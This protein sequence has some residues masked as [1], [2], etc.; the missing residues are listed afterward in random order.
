M[1][2]FSRT[3]CKWQG[4]K[5]RITSHF[6][7]SKSYSGS[8][9]SS[10]NEVKYFY[11]SSCTVQVL[12]TMAYYVHSGHRLWTNYRGRQSHERMMDTECLGTASIGFAWPQADRNARINQKSHCLKWKDRGRW[13]ECMELSMR[14]V[15]TMAASPLT[16]HGT[17]D[18]FVAWQGCVQSQRDQTFS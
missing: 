18:K 3:K 4:V 2:R 16:Y 17:F 1:S 14:I 6:A 11:Y 9:K 7:V 8:S 10:L 12:V 15:H 13:K 5:S